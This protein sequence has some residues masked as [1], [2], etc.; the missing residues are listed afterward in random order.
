MWLLTSLQWGYGNDSTYTQDTTITFPIS[1]PNTTLA[2]I[3]VGIN[4]ADRG[5]S[6][7]K[8]LTKSS[9]TTGSILRGTGT[10][11]YLVFGNQQW[12]VNGSPLSAAYG[13]W[14]FPIA[15]SSTNYW[16]YASFS[17]LTGKTG[18]QYGFHTAGTKTRTSCGYV[19]DLATCDIIAIGYQQWGKNSNGIDAP[20]STIT[21][22]I[23]FSST[24]YVVVA[25]IESTAKNSTGMSNYAVYKVVNANSF[26][27]WQYNYYITAKHWI[28]VGL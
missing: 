6:V 1:F 8:E 3:G 14:S 16:T 11:G 22:P 10:A 25:S 28:A 12:S 19:I 9:F 4:M 21:L 17:T 18:N 2:L 5:T 13:T 27:A 24:S 15:F 7:I 23:S 26:Q 20:A